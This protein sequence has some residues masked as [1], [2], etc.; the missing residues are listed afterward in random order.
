[1]SISSVEDLINEFRKE[2]RANKVLLSAKEFL[3]ER[4]NENI[5]SK[6]PEIAEIYRKASQRTSI[7]AN[8]TIKES[9]K[10]IKMVQSGK[11]GDDISSFIHYKNIEMNPNYDD[12]K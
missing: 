6:N 2:L 7:T 3:N 10:I 8:L 11:S 9:R 5:E 1:M 12:T 4:L